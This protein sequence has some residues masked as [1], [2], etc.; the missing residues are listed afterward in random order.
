MTTAYTGIASS[1]GEALRP[2]PLHNRRCHK[3]QYRAAERHGHILLCIP[4]IALRAKVIRAKIGE[5][6]IGNAVFNQFIHSR[7]RQRDFGWQHPAH[8]D[9]PMK[10]IHEMVAHRIR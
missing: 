4:H 8:P 3:R 7:E 10:L 2:H 9:R 1:C 6:D 5:E